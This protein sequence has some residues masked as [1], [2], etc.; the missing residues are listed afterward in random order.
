MVFWEKKI[1]IIIANFVE[2]PLCAMHCVTYFINPRSSTVVHVC[3]RAG[4]STLRPKRL[5]KSAP[6]TSGGVRN[7]T[8][9]D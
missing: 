1:A 5:K 6:G 4:M 9:A 3:Y 2:C 7:S 8:R